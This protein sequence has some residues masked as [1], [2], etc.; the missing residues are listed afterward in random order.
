MPFSLCREEGWILRPGAGLVF[1]DCW[2]LSSG[3]NSFPVLGERVIRD[4]KPEL[5]PLKHPCM[6]P[7]TSAPSPDGAFQKHQCALKDKNTHPKWNQHQRCWGDW[8]LWAR[9]PQK[10]RNS[11]PHSCF[12]YPCTHQTTI[13]HFNLSYAVLLTS[14]SKSLRKPQSSSYFTH[15]IGAKSP[16]VTHRAADWVYI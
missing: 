5:L 6:K 15:Q 3:R 7:A 4:L 10:A 16:P 14:L 13:R 9:T 12:K 1:K 2:S 11:L 8:P